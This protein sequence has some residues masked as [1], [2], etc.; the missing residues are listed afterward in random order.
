MNAI[1]GYIKSSFEE[2]TKV[3]WPTKK[4]AVRL[5]IIVLGFCLVSAVILGV[6]DLGLNE[7]YNQLLKFIASN[8]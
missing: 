1:T 4:R 8:R 2:L 5:T 7:G 3:V 6:V